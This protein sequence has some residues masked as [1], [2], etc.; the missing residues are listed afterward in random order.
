[1]IFSSSHVL[2][3]R[4]Q[5]PCLPGPVRKS[6]TVPAPWLGLTS[7]QSPHPAGWP[8][9]THRGTRGPSQM[10]QTE[11]TGSTNAKDPGVGRHP[12]AP[13]QGPPATR[14]PAGASTVDRGAGAHTPS[15][16]TPFVHSI[17]SLS[18][19]NILICLG[20][21][22]AQRAQGHIGGLLWSQAGDQQTALCRWTASPAGSPAF[23]LGGREKRFFAR[24]S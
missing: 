21:T 10:A 24:L 17:P 16:L 14:A 2:N 18:T 13:T 1:M 23:S 15:V 8:G 4:G 19:A 20:E 22:E 12:W 9:S 5:H 11:N 3:R 6:R 7:P